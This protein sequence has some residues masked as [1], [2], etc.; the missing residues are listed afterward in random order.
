MVPGRTDIEV[1]RCIK[2]NYPKP[3]SKSSGDEYTE[4]EILSGLY[5][6]TEIK[7]KI[8]AANYDMTMRITKNG[9]GKSLGG[10]YE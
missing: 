5:V 1:G 9:V 10:S 6:V 4:D 8:N 2:M 7:H 3:A